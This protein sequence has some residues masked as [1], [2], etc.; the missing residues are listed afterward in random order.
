MISYFVSG[1]K[2][3]FR[4]T[5]FLPDSQP[6]GWVVCFPPFAEEMNKCRG[7]M[8]A[9]AR[10]LTAVDLA[11]VVPDLFGTGD[12][13]GDFGDADWSTWKTDMV[14][15]VESIY[16]QGHQHVF[17]WGIRLGCL[18]ALDVSNSVSRR[19]KRII[20]WHPLPNGQ[21]AMTQFLRL[22]M[23]AGMME[24]NQEK[25]SDLRRQLLEDNSVEVAGYDLSTGLT[26]AIDGLSMASLAPENVNALTWFEISSSSEKPLSP[27]A[28]KVI[29][30]WHQAKVAVDSRKVLGDFFWATQEITMVPDLISETTGLLAVDIAEISSSGNS[31][32]DMFEETS[33][34]DEQFITFE[35]NDSQLAAIYHPGQSSAK[36]GILLVV[37]GPQYRVGSH[38]QFTLL[39]RDLSD[40]GIPVFRFD[41]RGM[42]DSTGSYIGFEGIEEDIS[43]ALDCFQKVHSELEEFV[44]WGLC[45]AATA[46]AFYAPYDQRVKGIVLLNPWVRSEQGQAQ[47]Y[48]R[49]YYLDRLL[50]KDF[51]LK[52][53]K[54]KYELTSSV[55]SFLGMV[56]SAK[57]N[58]AIS[59]HNCQ[60][61]FGS[62]ESNLTLVQR[63]EDA[64]DRFRGR[65]LLIISGN[66]LTAA[67][68][69]DAS[70]ESKRLKSVLEDERITIEKIE[71]ADHTFSRRIWRDEVSI[72]TNKWIKSW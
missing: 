22:R 19:I 68:F 46:A 9:Q 17:L 29:D 18:L 6:K 41:Y 12:S 42:G 56:K 2:G 45:D 70:M 26:N 11:V 40:A 50:S 23:A 39:A 33:F 53:I 55:K 15:L 37:G 27:I 24:G 16:Q 34:S 30:T 8:S 28:R 47:S 44:I 54:G 57:G 10:A 35:C 25:V 20:F 61:D 51:W 13:S 7:M 65:V 66:D 60:I 31:V 5:L 48:I 71:D 67:E 43:S 49:H 3:P 52:V 38:R 69:V 72:L 59:G 63:M 21:Q 1:C 64:L 58:G 36:R 62:G 32:A 14:N 4:I